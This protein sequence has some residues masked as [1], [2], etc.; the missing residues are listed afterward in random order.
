MITKKPGFKSL[1]WFLFALNFIIPLILNFLIHRME[2]INKS[3]QV[4]ECIPLGS[5]HEALT[6]R[7]SSVSG[8]PL[9]YCHGCS[10][11][12]CHALPGFLENFAC[13]TV[14]K[15]TLFRVNSSIVLQ[16]GS[17]NST[18]ELYQLDAACLGKQGAGPDPLQSARQLCVLPMM[19]SALLCFCKTSPMFQL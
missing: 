15:E 6:H 13:D 7:T 10:S 9:P 11:T 14:K 4:L 3:Y 2:M 18:A 16:H 19:C 12:I 5:L 8:S 17:V 1:I